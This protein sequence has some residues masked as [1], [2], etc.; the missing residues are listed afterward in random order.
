LGDGEYDLKKMDRGWKKIFR[1][2]DAWKLTLKKAR[3]LPGI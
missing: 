3:I 2:R 1:D